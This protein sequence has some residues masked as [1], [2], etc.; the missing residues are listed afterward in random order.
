MPSSIRSSAIL[1]SLRWDSGWPLVLAREPR[2]I[3]FRCVHHRHIVIRPRLGIANNP[4][5]NDDL[6]VEVIVLRGL[7]F[8]E[9]QCVSVNY[10]RIVV[11]GDHPGGYQVPDGI[12]TLHAHIVSGAVRPREQVRIEW[13]LAGAAGGVC[14]VVLVIGV[15]SLLAP[16][17]YSTARLAGWRAAHARCSLSTT[18]RPRSPSPALARG[19]GTRRRARWGGTSG[20]PGSPPTCGAARGGQGWHT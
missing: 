17:Q 10:Y 5:V 6:M 7:P 3:L 14:C 18:A 11:A 4:C 2:E 8:F 1:R 19:S 12:A 16:R 20:G 15:P 13:L 9:R